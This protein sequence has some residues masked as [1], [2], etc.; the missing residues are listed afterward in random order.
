MLYTIGAPFL[1]KSFVTL[2]FSA[3]LIFLV[4]NVA[5]ASDDMDTDLKNLEEKYD[6]LIEVNEGPSILNN[7]ERIQLKD[8]DELEILLEAF[9]EIRYADP[10]DLTEQYTNNSN[11][12]SG[13]SHTQRTVD[14]NLDVAGLEV[15]RAIPLS[16]NYDF[17]YDWDDPGHPVGSLRFTNLSSIETYATGVTVVGWNPVNHSYSL[18]SGGAFHGQTATITA[19]GYWEVLGSLGAFGSSVEVGISVP[20]SQSATFNPDPE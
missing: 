7:K 18:G 3:G 12:Q 20:D 14:V 16:M 6:V 8:I 15:S 4:G 17:M 10:I 5:D 19:T 13:T 2:S 11:L 9:N 1:K